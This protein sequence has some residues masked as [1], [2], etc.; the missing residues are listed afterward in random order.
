[1]TIN[2]RWIADYEKQINHRKSALLYG[3]IHDRFLWQ[4]N[5]HTVQTFLDNW[6]QS[7]GYEIILRFDPIEGIVFLSESMRQPYQALIR[8]SIPEAA[9]ATTPLN[10]M[11]A[12]PRANPGAANPNSQQTMEDMLGNL[13]KAVSQPHVS[14]LAI[15]HLGDMLTTDPNRYSP[16]ERNTL[17]LLHKATLE[18]QVITN[19]TMKGYR[20]TIVLIG[21]D[22]N[23][24]PTWFHTNNPNVGIVQ[25]T[26]PNKQ[27]RRQF[28]LQ[29]IP[30]FY[31]GSE[32]S[33]KDEPF[34]Q[35]SDAKVRNAQTELEKRVIG[36]PYA[37]R[38]AIN[39]LTNGKVGIS[40][41]DRSGRGGQPK[42]IFM[43]VGS[44]GVGKTELA[45][46]LTELVFGD[47]KAFARFDMSEYREEH[48]AEKLVGAPPGFVG[49]EEGGQL[50]NRLIEHPY[51]ILLFDEIEK[52]HPKVLD[53]FLQ[54]LDDGR[55]TDG[56]GQTVYFD[57]TII[58]FTSNIGASDLTDPQTGNLIRRGIMHDVREDTAQ[59]FPY[60]KVKEHFDAEVRWFFESR[61]GRSELLGRIGDENII[62]FD[63]LRP[64]F[65]ARIGMKFLRLLENSAL[66]KY[67]LT[68][69]WDAS[70]LAVLE[71]RM[72]EPNNQLL[73]GRRIRTILKATVEDP[74]NRWVFEHYPDLTQ[75]AG[76]RIIV[77]MQNGELTVQE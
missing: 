69:T 38:A 67:R 58:I 7:L 1:M 8:D 68:L 63:L 22:L 12:P 17:I 20:N 6:G 55:L 18:A 71:Q 3:N 16:E 31:G 65:V 66:E 33:E 24:V 77:G 9:Q 34:E 61:L 14:I 46:S 41:S 48:A 36:Q 11:A 50:T 15:V 4:S 75:L 56:K 5:Y 35:L 62:T 72:T 40:M 74:L 53:K 64:E 52:A 59:A 51:S 43:F 45:K 37:V 54:I 76:R 30:N 70:V 23:R 26:R 44:T 13:K 19:G 2:A 29:F 60:E 57:Q 42:A 32:L 47:E 49:Y 10:P 25:V 21:S 27:E 73:S 39:A 28:A